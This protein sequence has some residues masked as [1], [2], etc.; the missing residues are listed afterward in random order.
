MFVSVEENI[1]TSQAFHYIQFLCHPQL[2]PLLQLLQLALLP[3]ILSVDLSIDGLLKLYSQIP[4]RILGAVFS[5]AAP[6]VLS[7]LGS[8]D[9]NNIGAVLVSV[10]ALGSFW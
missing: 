10:V 8:S 9:G 6:A 4:G 5:A 7:W 2:F 1:C 3:T